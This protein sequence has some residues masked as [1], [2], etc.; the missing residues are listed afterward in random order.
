MIPFVFPF[1]FYCRNLKN[2]FA[3]SELNLIKVHFWSPL[4]FYFIPTFVVF[5]GQLSAENTRNESPRRNS[6][7][8]R[9]R[10]PRSLCMCVCAKKRPIKMYVVAA[11]GAALKMAMFQFA[12]ANNLK[13]LCATKMQLG[14][15]FRLADEVHGYGRLC[16]CLINRNN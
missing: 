6:R 11:R 7:K 10:F 13:N 1:D 16:F 8:S 3:P 12:L 4:L 15:R 2:Y 5:F 14:L 9:R